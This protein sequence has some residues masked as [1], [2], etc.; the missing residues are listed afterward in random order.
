MATTIQNQVQQLYVGLLGRAADQGGLNWWVDQV[1]T[2]GRTLDDI[3]ASFVTSEEYLSL[4]PATQTRA[5]MVT[6]IYQNLFERTPSQGEIDYWAVTDTRPADQLISAFLEFASA[7]DQI[8]ISNKVFVAN[9]YTTSVDANNFS[10]AGAAA[11]IADVDGTTAT[12]TTA[13]NS[14]SGGTLEGQVPGLSLINA[15]VAAANAVDT[16]ET[17]NQAAVNTLGATLQLSA[18]ALSGNFASDVT[19]VVTAANAA[20]TSASAEADTSVLV[21]RAATADT[22]LTTATNG[23]SAANRT[24]ANNLTAANTA[25]QNAKAGI[26]SVTEV[27]GVKAALNA[28]TAATAAIAARTDIDTL[29]ADYVT[30]TAA[31][32]TAIDSEFAGISTYAAFKAAAAKDAAY[33]DAI[34]ATVSAINALDSDTNLP[35]T[36]INGFNLTTGL[37]NGVSLTPTFAADG[38]VGTADAYLTALTNSVTAHN[39]L[40]AAQAADVNVAAANA[41]QTAYNALTT[42]ETN[43]NTA[44]T[45]FSTNTAGV[46]ITDLNG[47]PAA[48]ADKDVFYFADAAAAT[49]DYII[50]NFA[51][52]DSIVLGSGFTF[53]NGAL[54]TGNNNAAEFFLVNSNSG[55][56][57]VVETT[58]FGSATTV[59]DATTGVVTT[60]TDNVAIIT[61]TGVTADQLTVV[62]GVISH[63]A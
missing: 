33:A 38:T 54:S 15:Q 25:E 59:T 20:R 28:D 18:A 7:N 46:T 13:L 19:A 6:Q 5:E 8:T 55:V 23:L 10:K 21:A 14:I 58:A 24:L 44:I 45:N 22:A 62:N 41:F 39:T 9:T 29:Y 27:A 34:K 12:V 53:N 63:V 4:Y 32:R 48:T 26:A 47:A 56:Q 37:I 40:T 2:G 17:A 49:D 11:A 52:G 1:T 50:G 43:A 61:L 42:A 51:A 60:T 36:T 3:R 30:G 57:V 35:T 16:Y 31:Q